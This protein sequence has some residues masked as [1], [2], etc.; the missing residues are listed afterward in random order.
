MSCDA[1]Y[2]ILI[3]GDYVKNVLNRRNKKY[4][5]GS[6][7][8]AETERIKNH[9]HLQGMKLYRIFNYTA[10][11]LRDVVDRPD[12]TRQNLGDYLHANENKAL[13]DTVEDSDD[14]SVRRGTL[15]FQRWTIGKSAI[16]ALEKNR[17]HRY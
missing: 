5:D 11:P 15:A 8:L 16:K 9:P 3:D 2:A 17:R 12:G 13:I 4:P 14:F 7:V 1:R 6:A 10:V